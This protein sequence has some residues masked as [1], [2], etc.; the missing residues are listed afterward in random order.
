MG[1]AVAVSIDDAAADASPANLA[2][3]PLLRDTPQL[4]S[5]GDTLKLSLTLTLMYNRGNAG[6][7][8]AGMIML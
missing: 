8:I 7:D 2:V 1:A 5:M 3:T 4:A 6:V